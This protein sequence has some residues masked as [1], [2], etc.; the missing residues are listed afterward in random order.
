[1]EHISGSVRPDFGTGLLWTYG[2]LTQTIA[3]N[4]E[5]NIHAGISVMHLNRPQQSFYGVGDGD[6]L[7]M[8][9][10]VHGGATLGIHN[11][12]VALCPSFL[13][14]KQGKQNELTVGMLFKFDMKESSK[15]TG[16]IKGSSVY[17]GAYYRNK[18]AIIPY[19][20]FEFSAYSF[21]F[22]YDINTSGMTTL[23]KGRG[24]IEVSL[25]IANPNAFL[26]QNK[27]KASID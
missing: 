15:I 6:R 1:N 10:N 22:S 9:F 13:M 21:G 2:K 25:R 18:D 16:F 8:R 14:M 26:Y 7:K 24:G 27:S 17:L 12:N 20:G 11:T 23:S 3:S 19:F 5:N 4:D